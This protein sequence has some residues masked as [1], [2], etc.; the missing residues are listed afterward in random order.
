[1]TVEL[2]DSFGE[3][4]PCAGA[5]YAKVNGAPETEGEQSIY[6]V[7]VYGHP[8][9][10]DGTVIDN[11]ARE[12]LR[13][14]KKKTTATIGVTDEKRH[15]GGDDAALSR[16]AVPALAAAPRPREVLG[17]DRPLRQREPLQVGSDDDRGVLPQD[18]LD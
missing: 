4:Q 6:S 10:P 2:G 3:L 1:M 13:H 9:K 16:Q 8:T 14:R 5:F 11:I 7:I 18:V 12:R 17:V 15:D